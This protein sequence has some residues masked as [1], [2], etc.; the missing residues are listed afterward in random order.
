MQEEYLSN[1][2]V[3]WVYKEFVSLEKVMKIMDT[4][5]IKVPMLMIQA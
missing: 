1:V 2:S 3:I 5:T 4:M